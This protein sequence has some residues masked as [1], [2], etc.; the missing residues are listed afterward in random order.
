[1]RP[2]ILV[3]SCFQ[4]MYAGYHDAIRETWGKECPFEYKFVLG[5]SV[6]GGAQPLCMAPDTI[7]VQAPDDRDHLAHKALAAQRWARKAGHDYVL[8]VWNDTYVFGRRLAESGFQKW[9]YSGHFRGEAVP[10]FGK[11]ALGCYASGGSGYWLSPYATDKLCQEDKPDH[12]AD[13]LWVGRAMKK[14]GIQGTQD[15]RFFSAGGYEPCA[16][17]IHLSR[18]SNNYD[19]SWM[20]MTHEY[21]KKRGEL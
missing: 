17:T 18:G 21:A 8:Q 15:Y 1:M 13:D 10:Q 6:A 19:P 16:V 14:A 5:A 3:G 4:H 7:V 2:L 20:R 9:D 11:V 12:W